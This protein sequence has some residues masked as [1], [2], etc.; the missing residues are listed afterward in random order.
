M[1]KKMYECFNEFSTVIEV[2]AFYT[3][4]LPSSQAASNKISAYI[5]KSIHQRIW[6]VL[7]LVQ[8][9]RSADN[10]NLMFAFSDKR[11]IL[12]Q[13]NHAKVNIFK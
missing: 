4:A 3:T 5:C 6:K 8:Q 9:K 10:R 12:F 1:K 13:I 2:M 7:L 11:K